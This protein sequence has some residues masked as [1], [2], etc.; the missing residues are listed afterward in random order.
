VT[1]A[2]ASCGSESGA[3][4]QQ[5]PR[6]VQTGDRAGVDVPLVPLAACP[7]ADGIGID[8]MCPA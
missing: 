6:Q 4:Q 1:P 5:A 8:A 7:C 3:P 2:V